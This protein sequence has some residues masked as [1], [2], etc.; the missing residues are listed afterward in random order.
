MSQK[1][2]EKKE[3]SEGKKN[4]EKGTDILYLYYI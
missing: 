3:R 2:K 4:E 1:G